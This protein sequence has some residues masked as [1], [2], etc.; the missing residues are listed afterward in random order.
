MATM[1]SVI[2]PTRNHAS[3]VA[4]VLGSLL[5]LTFVSADV[6]SSRG[7]SPTAGEAQPE[8][9]VKAVFLYSFGR[10]VQWPAEAFGGSRDPF[11][12]GVLGDDPFGGALDKI[13]QTKTIQGRPIVVRRFNSLDDYQACHVL[14]IPKTT[15]A[16]WQAAA[17]TSLGKRHVLLVGEVPGFAVQGGTLGFYLERDKVRFQ[18]NVASAK[19]QRLTIDS[20]LLTLATTV[21]GP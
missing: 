18:I 9:N 14:F 21:D 2:D 8:Y 11:V 17:I 16:E 7:P 20:K 12:I 15:A 13:S 1:H 10:Y 3:R 19:R 4:A 5:A 6:P